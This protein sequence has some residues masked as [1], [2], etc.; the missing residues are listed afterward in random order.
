MWVSQIDKINEDG[1]TYNVDKLRS[2]KLVSR[3][4]R[5][6]CIVL[7]VSQIKEYKNFIN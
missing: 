1:N 4:N 3:N 5:L 6:N 7:K 2:S